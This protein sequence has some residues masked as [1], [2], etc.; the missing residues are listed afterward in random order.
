MLLLLLV[1]AAQL[2]PGNGSHEFRQ[3]QLAAGPDQV[4][5]TFGSGTAVYFTSS[6]DGGHR[7]SAPVRVAN[8]GVLALGRH[9]GPRVN[10]LPG[11]IVIS[12]VV[13]GGNLVVWRSTDRG[14][15]WT[16]PVAVTDTPA[17]A[18]A[19]FHAVASDQ[20]GNLYATWLDSR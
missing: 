10:L 6:D 12:A 14:K 18:R 4:V 11:A 2:Q 15:T 3:P 5:V 13:D 19:G 8:P 17:A 7:F 1:L 9:R 20:R 16:S